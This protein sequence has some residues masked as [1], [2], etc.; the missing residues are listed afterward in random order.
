M[1]RPLTSL[2]GRSLLK[3]LARFCRDDS[4]V[5]AIEF[6]ILAF[7]FFAIVGAILETS[8]VFLAGQF[9]DSAVQDASRAIRTGQLQTSNYTLQNFEDLVCSRLS[10][11]FSDCA[12]LQI[13]VHPVDD[14]ASATIPYP[15]SRTCTNTCPW[16][17]PEEFRPGSASN[18]VVVQVYYKWPLVLP[19]GPFS[20]TAQPDGTQLLGAVRVFR[21]EPF[22]S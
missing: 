2:I 6:G 1:S 7:P 10:G 9:L 3:P 4:G 12:G 18:T 8:I 11:L 14:F 13:Y 19:A 21:N 20:S 17:F 15:L 22:N 5:T 16:L